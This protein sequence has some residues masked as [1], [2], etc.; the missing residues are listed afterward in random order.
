MLS[1]EARTETALCKDSVWRKKKC[2]VYAHYTDGKI[3]RNSCF[4]S[5]VDIAPNFW[6]KVV[7]EILRSLLKLQGVLGAAEADRMKYSFGEKYL[8]EKRQPQIY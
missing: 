5:P 4:E 6:S 3:V 7:K 2:N 1:S 8:P